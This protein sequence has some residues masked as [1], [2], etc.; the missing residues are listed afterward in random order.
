MESELEQSWILEKE[1]MR[2]CIDLVKD[3]DTYN[4]CTIKI[5]LETG[6][7]QKVSAMNC[8]KI[9]LKEAYQMVADFIHK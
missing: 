8:K 7:S 5:N 9:T 4:I 2:T 1:N 3:G 6:N